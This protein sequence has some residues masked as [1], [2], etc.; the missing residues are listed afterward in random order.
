MWKR[1]QSVPSLHGQRDQPAQAQRADRTSAEKLVMDLGTSVVIMG[2]L[3]GSED[4]TLCGQMEGSIKLPAHTLTVGSQ[5]TIKADISAKA[6]V[7]TGAVIGNVMAA[8][9]VEIQA[10]GSVT[11]DVVSPRLVIADGGYLSSTVKM[12]VS[13]Q[14]LP[15]GRR[16]QNSGLTYSYIGILLNPCLVRPQR[17]TRSTPSPNRGVETF[18]TISRPASVPSATSFWR[19]ASRNRPSPS[20]SASFATSVWWT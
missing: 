13:A 9:K 5:A 18:W 11:G 14:A 7:I 3:S 4:L 15:E 12:P 8:D 19:W 20:T 6:I 2:E 10:T 17:R 1:D 16:R